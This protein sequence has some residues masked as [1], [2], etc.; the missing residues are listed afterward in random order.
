MATCKYCKKSGWFLRLD[1]AGLCNSCL[2]I[3]APITNRAVQIIEESDKI[4]GKSKK[5][6]TKLSRLELIE[7]VVK[8]H[9]LPYER[10]GIQVANQT[11]HQVLDKV[12]IMR[13][14]I[15]VNTLQEYLNK[16][17]DKAEKAKSAKSKI[18]AYSKVLQKITELKNKVSNP[19]IISE[20]E[21][22]IKQLLDHINSTETYKSDLEESETAKPVKMKKGRKDK[23]YDTEAKYARHK[24]NIDEYKA[25]REEGINLFAE[26]STAGF[27]VC[28]ICAEY[29]ERDNGY[30]KGIYTIEDIE[31]LIPA[32]DDCRC[33]ALPIT[34]DQIEEELKKKE[35]IE[36]RIKKQMEEGLKEKDGEDN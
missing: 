32:C 1:N 6:E 17:K 26:W 30:G 13:E 9:F 31:G 7:K 25:A 5:L 22:E 34:E 18:N 24:V 15:I 12:A 36:K 16:A 8:E 4:I 10:M 11:G 27:N 29:E 3:L 28:D 33:V 2:Q 20:L 19:D 21:L 14:E 23:T 35:E